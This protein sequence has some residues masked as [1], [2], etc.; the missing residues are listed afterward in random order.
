M[1]HPGSRGALSWAGGDTPRGP[2]LCS[3]GPVYLLLPKLGF[4][5]CIRSKG[6]GGGGESWD[7]GKAEVK[8]E[9]WSSLRL[10]TQE[11]YMQGVGLPPRTLG[12]E[13]REFCSEQPS[14]FSTGNCK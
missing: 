6:G 5:S 7:L 13:V 1:T 2:G 14:D 3:H 11:E 8:T 10:V 12:P 9:A 4:F